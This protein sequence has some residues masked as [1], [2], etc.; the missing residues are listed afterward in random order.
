VV[1]IDGQLY[2]DPL[3][4]A[5]KAGSEVCFLPALEGG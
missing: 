4:Q 5:L 3:L 2:P 1:A